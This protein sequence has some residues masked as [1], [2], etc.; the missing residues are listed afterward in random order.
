MQFDA[1]NLFGP[2]LA[3]IGGSCLKEPPNLP[4]PKALYEKF[5]LVF[6]CHPISPGW[7]EAIAILIFCATVLDSRVAIKFHYIQQSSYSTF[8]TQWRGKSEFNKAVIIGHYYKSTKL[9]VIWLDAFRNYVEKSGLL[10]C[11]SIFV[12]QNENVRLN[13]V[14]ADNTH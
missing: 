1:I 5:R 14:I 3:L 6:G 12:N 8:Q 13:D 4:T 11:K 2:L 7:W 9:E 10:K